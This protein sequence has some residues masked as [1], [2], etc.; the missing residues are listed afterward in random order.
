MNELEIVQHRRIDGMSMFFDTVDYRTPHFHSEWELIWVLENVLSVSCDKM[1]FIAREGD[2]I[3]FSP[4]QPHEFH[5]LDESCT[6]LCLQVS[7]NMLS[8]AQNLSCDSVFVEHYMTSEQIKS[9]KSVI[10]EIMRSYLEHAPFYE[11]YCTGM[12]YMVF[13]KLF[14][15]LPNH[16]VTREEQ[17]SI[18]KRNSRLTKLIKYVD[19]NYMHKIRLSD[20]AEEEGCSMTYMSH[21]VKEA[22]N[23]SFQDYVN[24]VRLNCAV[25]LIA[26]GDMKMLDVCEEA[27]FSD[28]RYFSK[29]FK[30]QFGM[31]PEQYSKL[32]VKPEGATVHRS[33][34]SIEKFYDD[35]Q[36]KRMLS[37]IKI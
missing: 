12:T 2:L 31:T 6:F 32:L 24:S 28:Y 34:H 22:L 9:L 1:T 14:S 20:F 18:S 26:G 21:F 37:M 25:K 4:N 23:Q 11:L 10:R 15:S 30:Q 33:L 5:K 13:G 16:V 7:A 27:G 17:E 36:S 29:T 8:T 19:S 3:L 35:E